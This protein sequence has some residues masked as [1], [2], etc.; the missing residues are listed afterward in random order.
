MPEPSAEVALNC[1]SGE[2]MTVRFSEHE[3]LVFKDRPLTLVLTQIKFS[4]ILSLASPAGVAGFQEA[5]RDDYEHLESEATLQISTEVPAIEAS[6]PIWHFSDRPKDEW[7][8]RVSTGIDFLSLET[9]SYTDFQE[10]RQKFAYVLDGFR[11]TLHPSGSV[12]VGLRKL[13]EFRH[14]EVEVPA[15]WAKWLKSE[16]LGLLVADIDRPPAFDF[17]DVRYSDDG[18]V[19]VL[20]V[21]HGLLDQADKDLAYLLDLDYFTTQPYEIDATSGLLDLLEDFSK[22]M[23]SFFH[24][25]ITPEMHKHLRPVPKGKG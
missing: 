12:R 22:G 19:T 3:D 15:D 13:N 20:S 24:W 21:R 18:G 2:Q 10:F 14:P 16:M 7:T 4:P 17:S 11:R 1:F 9:R 8:W 5:I 6:A 25:S 23:T